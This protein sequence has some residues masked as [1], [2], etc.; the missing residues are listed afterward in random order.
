VKPLHAVL[1]LFWRDDRHRLLA[2]IALNVATLLAGGALLGLSGWFIAASALAGLAGVGLAFDVFRPSAAIRLLALVRTASRYGER[3]VTHDATLRFVARL[4][5]SLFRGLAGLPFDRLAR[6]R[7]A[8]ALE[9]LTAD[10]E[11]LDSLYLRIVLPLVSAALALAATTVWLMHV[12]GHLALVVVALGFL[13]AIATA[14]G[15][16]A[17]LRVA[18]RRALA[19]E[20]LR[21]RTVDLVRAQADLAVAGSLGRQQASAMRAAAAASTAAHRLDAIDLVTGAAL[22]LAGSIALLGLLLLAAASFR[23]G[24]IGAATVAAV[25]LIGFAVLEALHPLRRGAVTFGRTHLAARRLAPLLGERR[26]GELREPPQAIAP[27]GAPALVF[28]GTG[29]GYRDGGVPAIARLDLTIAAGEHI[30]L[31]GPSG[32]GKSTLLALAAGLLAP[33]EGTVG[34]GGRPVLRIG[35]LERTALIGLLTQRTELFGDTIA[36]NLR[37]AAPAADESELWRALEAVCLAQRVRTTNEGLATRLG[38]GGLGLSGGEARRLALAR[39]V[40]RHPAIWLLDEPAAGLDAA[41]A[42]TVLDNVRQ[43]A[44]GATLVVA[45]HRLPDS[46]RGCRIIDLRDASRTARST[47]PA[48]ARGAA[49]PLPLSSGAMLIWRKAEA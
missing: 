34:L 40:L 49:N 26:S 48:T 8:E 20:A 24:A 18:R 17:G 7:G 35:E 14:A 21:V 12:G 38:D 31:A 1:A 6:L 33:T 16:L 32:S 23:A 30:V 15:G 22:N 13:G 47:R 9:R 37:M 28:S 3:L 25:V 41:L 46:L 10:I 36:A 27:A 42:E 29:F 39:I 19:L 44:K 43:A 45:T 4:R 2:G 5:V 11:A